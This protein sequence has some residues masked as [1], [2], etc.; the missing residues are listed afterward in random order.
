MMA[1][2]QPC[3]LAAALVAM[4]PGSKLFTHEQRPWHSAGLSGDQLLIILRLNGAD[5]KTQAQAF[6][7][8]LPEAEFAA[9]EQRFVADIQ[10]NAI[11]RAKDS[12][13]TV[14]IQALLIDE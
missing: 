1:E 8:A 2:G 11:R 7:A 5:S 3:P 13:V 10:V 9:I 4:L 14:E 6:A 12:A